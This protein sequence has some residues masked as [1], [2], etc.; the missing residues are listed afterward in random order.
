MTATS[1]VSRRSTLR[2]LTIA[3]ALV[4][5]ALTASFGSARTDAAIPAVAG[6]QDFAYGEAPGGDDVTAGRSQSKLWTNGGKWWGVL[7]D[8]GTIAQAQ[9]RIWK[10]DMATQNWTNT[11]VLVDNRNRSHADVLSD[12]NTLYVV[13]SRSEDETGLA[14]GRDVRI[15]RYTYNT[16]TDA[17]TLSG[18]DPE[19]LF[20]SILGH[21]GAG[22]V[23]DVGPDVTSLAKGDHVT[24]YGFS[25]GGTT[26]V[27]SPLGGVL[28]DLGMGFVVM[29]WDD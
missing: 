10:F 23:V 2:P 9:F 29:L 7:F 1:R 17:Y 8:I 5:V 27:T 21:E 24:L 4:F 16:T 18:K 25:L 28:P 19:G 20:P 14:T 12:G 3:M 26:V 6:Y 11:N 22:V 13:S 15:Y